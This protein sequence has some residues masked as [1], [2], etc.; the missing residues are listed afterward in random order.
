[1]IS[2]V[3]DGNPSFWPKVIL[4]QLNGTSNRHLPDG[5]PCRL[6]TVCCSVFPP[7]ILSSSFQW[8]AVELVNKSAYARPHLIVLAGARL[9][10]LAS[11]SQ[12]AET[13]CCWWHQAILTP[14][15]DTRTVC[16]K[17]LGTFN[18]HVCRRRTVVSCARH[19]PT[20]GRQS[21]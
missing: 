11:E 19:A 13:R 7:S 6:H 8:R 20:D 16:S 18:V 9:A 14:A 5:K 1:M 4:Q 3:S 21:R 12:W 2:W 17:P 10:R 15:A